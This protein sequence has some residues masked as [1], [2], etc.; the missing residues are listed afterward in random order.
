MRTLVYIFILFSS[1]VLAQEVSISPDLNLRN[2]F[3]YDILGDV[4]GK[5]IVFRDKGFVK[6]LDVFNRELELVQSVELSF[7]EK[8]VDVFNVLEHDSVF[9]MLY[10]YFERDSMVFRTRIYNNQIALVD[11]FEFARLH[12]RDVRQKVA[13]FISEDKNSILL[14]THD[15]KDKLVFLLYNSKE[16]KLDWSGKVEVAGDFNSNLYDIVVTNSGDFVVLLNEK[17]WNTD[18]EGMSLFIVSPENNYQKFIEFDLGGKYYS[19]IK[20]DYDNR[21]RRFLIC[22]SYSEKR[23]KEV[24]GYFYLSRPLAQINDKQGFEY[25]IFEE[26]LYEELLQGRKRKSRVLEDIS[27]KEIIFRNDG[28]FLLISE[29]EREYSRRNPYNTYARTGYDNYSRRAWIDFYNDDIIVSNISPNGQM[30]WNK[31]LYKKQFSQDDDGIY[32]SFFVLKTPSRL[33]FIYNDEIKKNNT[34]SEYLLDPAGKIARNSLLSTAY[35]KMKLRFKDAVQIAPNALIVP[36]ENSYDLNL[37][38]ITY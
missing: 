11:S 33:R 22:G 23:G 30:L 38:R 18:K 4:D 20:M 15:D 27:L 7:E 14:S 26:T 16:K 31:V 10:G 37:V 32:S 19:N 13:S 21:N 17:T 5:S 9:Q 36:S 28:G 25:L 1:C 34:V 29:I 35:Q 6:E 3:S 12:K 24:Q 2:Y 8:R